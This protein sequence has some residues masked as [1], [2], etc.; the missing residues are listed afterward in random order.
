[1]SLSGTV[2]SVR[3]LPADH[4]VASLVNQAASAYEKLQVHPA[5]ID[6]M[7]QVDLACLSFPI[8]SC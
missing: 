2:A 7:E 4:V 5:R 6:R 1:M 8:L 3:K